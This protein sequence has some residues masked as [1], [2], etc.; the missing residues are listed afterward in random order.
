MPRGGPRPNSGGPRP[1]SGPKPKDQK[2]LKVASD[3]IRAARESGATPLDY[4]LAV[5]RDPDADPQRRDR[6]AQAAAPYV[7]P[8]AEAV[9]QGKKEAAREAAR[10]VERGTDWERLLGPAN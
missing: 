8:R 7:H 10:T 3:I 4:M 9:E 2:A 1:G 5:M 6:M